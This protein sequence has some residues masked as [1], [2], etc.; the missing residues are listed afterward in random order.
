M[1]LSKS[2]HVLIFFI[3]S[4]LLLRTRDNMSQTATLQG[5]AHEERMVVI[6]LQ[7]MECKRKL[8]HIR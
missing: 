3:W 4:S 1:N 5:P 2:V 8:K 7:M 6:R